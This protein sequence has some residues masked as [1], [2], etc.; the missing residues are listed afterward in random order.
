MQPGHYGN[1]F[2]ARTTGYLSRCLGITVPVLTPVRQGICFYLSAGADNFY[3]LM[4][5]YKGICF[6]A[7]YEGTQGTVLTVY[8]FFEYPGWGAI[9]KSFITEWP[10]VVGSAPL[11]F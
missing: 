4:S 3:V 6:G 5:G 2:D 8:L 1:C 7:R 9:P 11:L 10:D